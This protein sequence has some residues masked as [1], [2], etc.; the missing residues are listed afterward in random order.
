ME[1][2]EKTAIIL[3]NI[4]AINWGL[5]IFDFN[6]VN[7]LVGSWPIVEKIVYALVAIGG[8]WG[9]FLMFKKK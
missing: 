4:G 8:I 3:A 7:V 9:L 5:T 2:Y 6:L 1:W